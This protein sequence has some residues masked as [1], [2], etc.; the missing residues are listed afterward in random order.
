MKPFQ[1]DKIK[2]LAFDIDGTLFSSENIILDTYIESI[3]KFIKSSGRELLIPSKEK[4]IKQVGLPVKQIF[5]NLLP[6]LNEEERDSISDNVLVLLCEKIYEKK[7]TLYSGVEDCI[8]ELFD[9]KYILCIAS[10]GR[11]GYINAILDSY[12][13]LSYFKELVVIDYSSIQSK[14]DILKSYLTKFNMTGEN[15]LMIGDRKSDWEAANYGGSPF[16]FCEYGHAEPKEIDSF[17]LKL[18]AIHDL[19]AFL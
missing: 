1:K 14:G 3:Q 5:R 19:L 12:K 8:K 16:A 6:E 18:T 13:L 11:A 2:I 17:S 9:R 15:A 10:N 7:G 4:I